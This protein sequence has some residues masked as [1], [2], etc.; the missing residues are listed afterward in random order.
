MKERPTGGH[1]VLALLVVA[2]LFG[3]MLYFYF[4]YPEERLGPQQPIYF[5]HRIHAGVK[6]I[7][8]R[9]CHP[10]VDRSQNAGIPAVA[11][12]FF[13]HTYIIPG[14]PQ[15]MK[16]RW[17]LDTK[18]PV[19]WVRVFYIPDYVKFNHQPHIR[20][21]IDCA[22]CHGEVKRYDRLMKVD[23]KMAFCVNCHKQKNAPLDCWLACHH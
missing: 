22:A 17:H 9:F 20:T 21:G 14:H 18:T 8:C 7:S 15:I 23:F 6:E 10:Y 12:C 4:V 13:C 11:L 2:I 1:W 19:P 3:A 16:E 5:S